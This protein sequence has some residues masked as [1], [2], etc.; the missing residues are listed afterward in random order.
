MSEYTGLQKRLAGLKAYPDVLADLQGQLAGLLP[1]DFLVCFSWEQLA[2]FPRYLKAAS[3]RLDKLRNN[4]ARDAQLMAEWK[5]LANAWEREALNK[6]RAGVRDEQV[7]S[8]RWLLEE[9]RVGLYAQELKTPMPVSVKRL[10][11]IWES[12]PR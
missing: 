6:R 7:E 10:Q 4:P 3:V 2:Q 12:R 9:L 11:K 5:S 1:K 8:F